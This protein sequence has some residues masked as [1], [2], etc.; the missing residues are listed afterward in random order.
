MTLS[1]RINFNSF[2]SGIRTAT[3]VAA[4]T[5]ATASCVIAEEDFRLRV[6]TAFGTNLPG[7]GDQI[8]TI[9][10]QISVLTEGQVQ[11]RAFEPGALVDAAS[12]TQAV[13]DNKVPVGYT[14]LGYDQGRIPASVL[15][16]AG[17]PFGF[18]PVEFISWWFE[19]D[20]KALGEDLYAAH[21]IHPIL[22]GL[23]GPETAGWYRKEIT[24][25]QDFNGLNIRFAGLG[26][27]LLQQFGAAITNLP[28]G[29]LFSALERGAI[30]ATEYNTPQVDVKLGFYKIAEF[31]Y[32]PGWHQGFTA[33][34][35]VVNRDVW[36]SFS[37]RQRAVIET[38]CT[39]GTLRNLARSEYLAGIQMAENI[40]NGVQVRTL[41]SEIL[42]TL[43]AAYPAVEAAQ[44]EA[45]ANFATIVE[46]QNTF[47]DT[48]EKWTA[49]G[50][51]QR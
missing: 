37:D 15:I 39:G 33:M 20:G 50:Y 17:R 18:E 23:N 47:H 6:A 3:A 21:N 26:G 8:V 19:G 31:N 48:Y 2:K 44:I 4:M 7:L 43:E 38:A 42:E 36:N 27:Q 1:P 5:M 28:G 41:S 11:M 14:W 29:E 12:I 35:L 34:H 16:S 32:F 10:D 49:V 9:A 45:D 22:C 25:I 40:A 51:I 13:K 30:D 24:N 46:S